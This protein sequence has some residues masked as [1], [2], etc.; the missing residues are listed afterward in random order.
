MTYDQCS[1]PY[2][3]RND[4]T[5]SHPDDLAV[6]SGW[7]MANAACHL[8][9]TPCHRMSS[10]W[11][12]WGWYLI[13]MTY[14]QCSVSSG[15]DT[16]PPYVI[17][18]SWLGLIAHMDDLWPMQY[19]IWMRHH[20]TVCHPDKLAGV[21]ISYGWLMANAVCHLDET[22]CHRMSSGWVCWGWYP[23][24]MTYGQCS[25]SSGWDTMPP[26]VTRMSWLGL[27]SHTDDL[28]PTQYVIR[29]THHATLC[30]LDEL[31]GADISSG[32]VA[33]LLL[34]HP[35]DIRSHSSITLMR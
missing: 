4:A 28:L 23:I 7:L 33:A 31:A 21:D 16:M 3:W 13:R 8:D 20:A 30:L 5:L 9:E 19:V 32:W 11:V 1:I 14:G 6:S 24:R 29:M 26:Y 27:I 35:D 15:W 22:S 34:C 12:G 17:R 18:M 2:G 25:V 10:G